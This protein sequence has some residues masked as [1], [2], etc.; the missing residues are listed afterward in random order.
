[1]PRKI[2]GRPVAYGPAQL[3]ALDKFLREYYLN[4]LSGNDVEL[5]ED[6]WP[7]H[8]NGAAFFNADHC[9]VE[10]LKAH[11]YKVT[12]RQTSLA[13]AEI[14]VHSIQRR[15]GNGTR[16]RIYTTAI[17][18]GACC[19]TSDETDAERARLRRPGWHGDWVGEPWVQAQREYGLHGVSRATVRFVKADFETYDENHRARRC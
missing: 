17:P 16:L 12:A 13:M 19:H 15:F 2:R 14:G 7:F 4:D 11:N 10:F 1:M 18:E 6:G 5:L 8:E 3:R 9:H